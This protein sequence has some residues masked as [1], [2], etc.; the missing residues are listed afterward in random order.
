M[1]SAHHSN[2]QRLEPILLDESTLN[3]LQ[4]IQTEVEDV[5]KKMEEELSAIHRKHFELMRPLFRERSEFFR[6]TPGLWLTALRNHTALVD[7]FMDDD[8]QKAMSHCIDIDFT[9]CPAPKNGFILRME[10]KENPYFENKFLEK[11]FSKS[12]KDGITKATGGTRIQWKPGMNIIKKVQQLNEVLEKDRLRKRE[13]SKNDDESESDDDPIE[14]TTF[15]ELFEDEF[16][17]TEIALIIRDEVYLDPVKYLIKDDDEDEEEEEEEDEE[18]E[19]E[20]DEEEDEDEEE[21]E[22]NLNRGRK[23]HKPSKEEEEDDEGEDEDEE[24]DEEE[25]DDEEKDS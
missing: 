7:F 6:K 13:K 12:E 5:N 23:M 17:D 21:E 9:D 18:G 24:E 16:M 20:E 22:V 14:L 2:D 1:A 4:K 10:F 15:F 19:D 25:E 3:E 11:E 8:T